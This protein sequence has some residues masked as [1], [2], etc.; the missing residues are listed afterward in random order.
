VK[1][2]TGGDSI[3]ARF[4][5]AEFFDFKPTHKLWL[6]TN[7]KPEIRGTDTAIWRRIR[8]IPFTE[9]IPP[10]E[11][12]KRL[13]D[14]LRK[15]RAGILQWAVEG[16]LEWQREGLQAPDEVR[17]ATRAYRAEMDVIAAFIEEECVVAAN[18]TATAKA[19]Y[20][21]YKTWCEANGERPESQ[22]RFGGR[23]RERGYESGRITTGARKGAVEWY[24]I[25]LAS[26]PED[27]PR[28]EATKKGSPAQSRME[29]PQTTNKHT[30]GEQSEPEINI[31]GSRATPRG[32]N[33]EKGSLHSLGSPSAGKTRYDRLVEERMAELQAACPHGFTNGKGC[34]LC[35]PEHPERKGSA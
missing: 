28:G 21:A 13:P 20:L 25:G 12:D 31:N 23:L 19:L 22:R 33:P 17:K 6:S 5:R 30:N 10:K 7:H 1:D 35:D 8:L 3:T 4:M 9:T 34:Y 18:A 32:D 29:K 2:L 26:G 16:C 11:Q 24:G 14:K 15:E 27:P